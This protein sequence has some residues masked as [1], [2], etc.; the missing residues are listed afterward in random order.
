MA[1]SSVKALRTDLISG[2]FQFLQEF[3]RA[4]MN[5]SAQAIQPKIPLAVSTIPDAGINELIASSEKKRNPLLASSG[6]STELPVWHPDGRFEAK[7]SCPA[8]VTSVV[9][10]QQ[11]GACFAGR[12]VQRIGKVDP[13]TTMAQRCLNL[14]AILDRNSGQRDQMRQ[15]FRHLFSG[16]IGDIAQHPLE[17]EDHGLWNKDVAGRKHVRGNPPLSLI[18]AQVKTRKDVG[19]NGAHASPPFSS[20]AP[21][22]SCL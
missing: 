7:L 1:R 6:D 13:I 21:H 2:V 3:C 4:N 10:C 22:A 19:V 20:P 14:I 16:L 5:D 17:L 12:E 18:I 9:E 11:L 8:R 15:A